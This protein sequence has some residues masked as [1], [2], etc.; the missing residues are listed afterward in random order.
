MTAPFRTTTPTELPPEKTAA[1]FANADL[2]EFAAAVGIQLDTPPQ[3]TPEPEPEAAPPTEEAPPAQKEPTSAPE[4]QVPKETPPALPEPEPVKPPLTKFSVRDGE[5]EIEVP[6]E[7][8]FSFKAAG[9]HYEDV[10]LEKV[11]LL[12]QMG[13]SNQEREAQ[14]LGAKRF[15]A[16]TQQE[17]QALRSQIEEYEAYMGRVF[18]DPVFSEA[19]RDNYS[20]SN[21]PEERARRAEGELRTERERQV[22]ASQDNTR[23]QF[24]AQVLVPRVSSLLTSHPTLTQEEL[25]GRY[26]MLTAPLMVRGAVPVE[27]LPEVQYLVENDLAEWARDTH[28]LREMKE[29]EGDGAGKAKVVAAQTEAALAKRKLARAVAPSSSSSSPLVREPQKPKVYETAA[30]WLHD[31]LPTASE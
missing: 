16:A 14:V 24:A 7:L 12:A 23:A 1:D 6:Q 30:D 8:R 21:S 26:T 20:L 31:A 22:V 3:P 18:T 5:G 13:V 10:P 4:T 29:K 25:V 27:R 9:K 28:A 15:V 19:A 2:D 11:V 17:N